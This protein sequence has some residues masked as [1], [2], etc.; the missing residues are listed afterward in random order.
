MID[1]F[2]NAKAIYV[3]YHSEDDR[4]KIDHIFCNTHLI[5]Y[6][7]IAHPHRGELVYVR[8][9]AFPS[10][11]VRDRWRIAD[12]NHDLVAENKRAPISEEEIAQ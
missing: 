4:L 11:D 2:R 8:N 1:S 5:F 10:P 6:G 12:I 3:E 9:D 7:K